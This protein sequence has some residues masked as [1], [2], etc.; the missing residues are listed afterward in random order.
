MLNR[1][2]ILLSSATVIGTVMLTFV[3]IAEI[4][5]K[6]FYNPSIDKIPVSTVLRDGDETDPD[7]EKKGAERFCRYKKYERASEFVMGYDED[8]DKRGTMQWDSNSK[9]W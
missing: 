2:Q 6:V 5:K 1:N 8:E 9:K 4:E 3:A 7:D